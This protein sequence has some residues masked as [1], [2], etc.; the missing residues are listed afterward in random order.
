MIARAIAGREP[1]ISN[2]ARSDPQLLLSRLTVDAGV[3]SI[4]VLPLLVG[5]EAVAVLVLYGSEKDLFHAEEMKLLA[6]E[7]FVAD[8]TV[9]PIR[10][11]LRAQGRLKARI[12]QAS[13]VSYEPVPQNIDEGFGKALHVFRLGIGGVYARLQTIVGENGEGQAAVFRAFIGQPYG[14]DPSLAVG[15]FR[16]RKLEQELSAERHES[17]LDS[18]GEDRV[19]FEKHFEP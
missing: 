14:G 4:V 5:G 9:A 17:C 8:L 10:G 7:S 18:I 6:V 11:G 19:C 16:H 13:V 15:S 3:Q 2:D 12:V 1:I